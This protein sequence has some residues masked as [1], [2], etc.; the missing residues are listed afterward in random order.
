VIFGVVQIAREIIDDPQL[1]AN[2]IV[3]PLELPGQ[4]AARTVSSP[5]QIAGAPKVKPAAAPGLGEHGA[6][7]VLRG[8]GLLG[9]GNRGPAQH[10]RRRTVRGQTKRGILR[11]DG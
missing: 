9:S 1:A 5:I 3:V 7:E 10:R 2:D 4:P 8:A 11:D 6:R